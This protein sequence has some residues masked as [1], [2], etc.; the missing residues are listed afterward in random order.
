MVVL[1][2]RERRSCTQVEFAAALG[3][4]VVSVSKWEW[5]E[6]SPSARLRRALERMAVEVGYPAYEW[7]AAA[8]A[9]E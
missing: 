7:P 5:G 6:N 8:G 3:R 1:T 4:S 9:R 2:V